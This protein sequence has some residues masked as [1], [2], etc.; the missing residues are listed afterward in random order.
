MLI[1]EIEG[2]K[3]P[4]EYITRFFFKEK[5]QTKR[6]TVLELGSGNGNNLMLFYQYGWNVIGVDIDNNLI[7]QAKNNF[8]KIK[9]LNHLQNTYEHHAAN[10]VRYIDKYKGKPVDALL[11]P[12]SIYYLPDSQIIKLLRKIKSRRLLAPRGHIFLTVRTPEDYR[13]NRGKRISDH[14]YKLDI[15]ETGERGCT[16][17]FFR[18]SEIIKL[19]EET[20]DLN[21]TIILHQRYDNCQ[22]GLVINNSDITIWGQ[23]K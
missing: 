11:F 18:E 2:L 13:Y 20:F 9:T 5:L 15:S 16:I 6:G 10:M 17:S 22:N 4:V 3:Y 1:E 7:Q 12:H 21:K 8:N 19:L 14:C 23:V